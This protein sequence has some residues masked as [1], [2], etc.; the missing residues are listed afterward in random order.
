MKIAINTRLL[1][2]N[3]LEGIGWFTFENF[4]RITLAHPEHDFYFLFDRSYS[5]ELIFSENVHPVVV[6]PHAGYPLTWKFW[7]DVAVPR[8]LKRIKPDLFIS[9][10]GFL[11]LTTEVP[12]LSV[13]HDINFFHRPDD[14]P[15]LT[16]KYYSKYFPLFAQKAKRIVT[17]SE[18]SKHDICD[19]YNISPSKID[20]VYN[21]AN[22]EYKP[23][24]RDEIAET[25]QKYSKGADYF[26]FIGS[27]QPRKNVSGLLGAFD[28]FV[29]HYGTDHKVIIV[30]DKH[31]L[32]AEL[33]TTYNQMRFGDD[34]IFTGRLSTTE[35][36]NVLGAA[37][38]LVFVPFFEGFGIPIV[39]AMSAGVPVIS[40]NTTSMP[41]VAG[42]AAIFVDP[43][44]INAIALAM[45]EIS[46]DD[47]L[48]KGL[49]EKGR[50]QGEK[51]NWDTSA[52]MLWESIE[53]CLAEK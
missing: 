32:A 34:V 10:D 48:R 20:V 37:T 9:P 50:K 35:L 31:A 53:R 6:W 28:L 23:L 42:D 21:G 13:I 25:K 1:I 38:A 16:R 49:I 17:V 40:S 45:H 26:L 5:K 24:T 7:F 41:E 14:F 2:Q 39:E 12:Q 51:F 29:S 33:D 11:S 52:R 27:L 22:K 46:T 43:S 47:Q 19:S 3:K 8:V 30:G 36:K 18:F 4:K 15:Y 44:D